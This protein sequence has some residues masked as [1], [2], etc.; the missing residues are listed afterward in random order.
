MTTEAKERADAAALKVAFFMPSILIIAGFLGVL[1]N[2]G[3]KGGGT[4]LWKVSFY[5]Y[6][7]I[8]PLIGLGAC[9]NMVNPASL[10]QHNYV[11]PAC[12]AFVCL[13]V[14]K[15][16]SSAFELKKQYG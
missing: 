5:L 4:N 14:S 10:E 12:V 11:P 13:I 6:L 7:L 16:L 9:A 8:F 1:V 2:S 15:V 3:S